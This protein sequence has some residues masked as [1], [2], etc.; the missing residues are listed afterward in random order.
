MKARGIFSSVADEIGEMIVAE[1]DT[2]KVKALADKKA[3]E[4]FIV[5]R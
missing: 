3:V 5:E 2:A 1:V 4:T